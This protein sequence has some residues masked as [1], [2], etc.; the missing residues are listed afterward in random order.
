MDKY[1]RS[2]FP[3]GKVDSFTLD[4]EIRKYSFKFPD[5]LVSIWKEYGGGDLYQTETILYPLQ[6]DKIDNVVDLNNAYWAD[7]MPRNNFVFHIGTGGVTAFNLETGEVINL[8][9]DNWNVTCRYLSF[10]DWFK[11]LR[12]ELMLMD[13]GADI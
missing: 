12:N 8:N 13:Y 4:N 6:N 1:P 11:N 2:F 5:E 9:T 3:F 10:V 7:G